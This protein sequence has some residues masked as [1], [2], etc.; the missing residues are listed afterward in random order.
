[1]TRIHF[2][3]MLCHMI[4]FFI[5]KFNLTFKLTFFLSLFVHFVHSD[6]ISVWVGSL[7]PTVTYPALHELFSRWSITAFF[8]PTG[9]ALFEDVFQLSVRNRC[10]PRS[11]VSQEAPVQRKT[12][13]LA[14]QRQNDN[15]VGWRV[16]R[17]WKKEEKNFN[18]NVRLLTIVTYCNYI[19][20]MYCFDWL[21]TIMD[22]S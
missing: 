22:T 7:S 18:L 5:K 6:L 14:V 11:Q 3:W 20:F 16:F 4:L 17:L 15:V 21:W 8:S 2:I 10:C 1:M 13:G 9:G 12:A 19:Y